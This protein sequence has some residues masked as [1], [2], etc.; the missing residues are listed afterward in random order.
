MGMLKGSLYPSQ[1]EWAADCLSRQDWQAQPHIVAALV[2]AAR[3]DP[4]A[5]V[6]AGCVRALGKMKANTLPVVQTVQSLKGDSDP[7]VRHEVD[8]AL[9]ALGAAP[10]S[11]DG[12]RPVSATVPADGRMP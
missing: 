9:A 4:A 6:R 11:H 2:V 10:Q 1:R 8:E 3:E 5:A 7:R 12:I